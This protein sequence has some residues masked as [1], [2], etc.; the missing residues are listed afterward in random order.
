MGSI[1]ISNL[2][3]KKYKN[4][5]TWIL[6][7]GITNPVPNS[8]LGDG[9]WDVSNSWANLRAGSCS[10][11]ILFPNF[12]STPVLLPLTRTIP[13]LPGPS[14]SHL[15]PLT[16]WKPSRAAQQLPQRERE[17]LLTGIITPWFPGEAPFLCSMGKWPTAPLS[18]TDQ[19]APAPGHSGTAILAI[20]NS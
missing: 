1:S 15:N 16:C 3:R 12:H 14:K 9:D 11:G 8:S 17:E 7:E 2:E 18:I 6:S 13:V 10:K 4:Q 19:R 20:F 5:L